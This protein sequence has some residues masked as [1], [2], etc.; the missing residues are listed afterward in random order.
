MASKLEHGTAYHAK[1]KK[2]KQN[3][4][5]GIQT[6]IRHCISKVRKLKQNQFMGVQT[7]IWHFKKII[8]KKREEEEPW[9]KFLEWCEN[10]CGFTF[11]EIGEIQIKYPKSFE[12]L[13]DIYKDE[14]IKK[15]ASQISVEEGA[16]QALKDIYDYSIS[17]RKV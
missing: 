4:I 8:V 16:I 17:S 2:M 15:H 9:K 10:D 11:D 14:L 13:K 6:Y 3:S 12:K 5:H 7:C 1:I